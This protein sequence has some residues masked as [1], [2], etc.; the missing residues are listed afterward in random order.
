M[1]SVVKD[2]RGRSPYWIACYTDSTGRRLKKSTKLTNKKNALEVALALEHGEDQAR[3]GAFTEARLR[4]LLEQTLERVVGAPVQ[5]YTVETWLNW[6]HERKS[7]ARPA[8]AERYGQVARDFIEFLGPRAKLPLEHVGVKDIL[9]F[10]NAETKRG[11]SNK[12]ANLA[13]K[14]ISMAF[15]DALRQGKIKFNPCAGLDP[16][17]EDSAEREPFALDEIRKL[18][19]AATGDW[20]G[21]IMFAYFTGARLGDV[22]NIQWSAV[23]LDKR[24]ISFTPKKTKRGKKVLKIPLHPALEKQLLKSPGV[25]NAPLFPSLAGRGSGGAHGLSAEFKTIMQKAGVHGAIIRHTLK[26]R[27]N[28]TKSFHSLRHSFNSALANAGIARELRQVLTGHASAAM[29][30]VYTHRELEPLR[31]AVAALPSVKVRAR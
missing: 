28:T 3:K 10:R 8:S 20:P 15:H 24:L 4:D 14:L 31:A 17:E 5:H 19:E 25:G 27:G 7:K 16:L 13:V 23:D 29:N 30:E 6:W 12:T 9:A 18:L 11:V 26:G 21:A 22:A 1:A 2:P